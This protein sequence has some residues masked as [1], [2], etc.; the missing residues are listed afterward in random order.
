M[1]CPCMSNPHA[2]SFPPIYPKCFVACLPFRRVGF[3]T[4][5]PLVVI[6]DSPQAIVLP[7]LLMVVPYI[8]SSVASVLG[9]PVAPPVSLDVLPPCMYVLTPP[10]VTL[11][12]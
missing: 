3:L 7:L 11:H 6:I 9:P 5:L 2:L 4:F 12:H 8:L 10:L 1:A